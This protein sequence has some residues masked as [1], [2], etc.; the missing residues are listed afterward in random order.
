[1][2][3]TPK[4]ESQP[5]TDQKEELKGDAKDQG[6]KQSSIV[7]RLKAIDVSS[8]DR[9]VSIRQEQKRV[10]DYRARAEEKK[11]NVSEVV[12]KRVNDD[13]KKRAASLEQQSTPLRSQARTEYKKLKALID[14]VKR[15]EEQTRLQKDELEFRHSVGE[16]SDDHLA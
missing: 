5:E 16:L 12:Y 15:T 10:D 11:S 14:E 2:K 3:P 1:M 7:D 6:D 9:L 13:Y 8:L 4:A